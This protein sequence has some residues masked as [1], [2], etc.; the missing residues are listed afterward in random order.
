MIERINRARQKLMESVEPA[1]A[2]LESVR[3][4][5]R[6][7]QYRQ[8][9]QEGVGIS[10]D[11]LDANQLRELTDSMWMARAGIGDNS[12]EECPF[13]DVIVEAGDRLAR[14]GVDEYAF[15]SEWP[16]RCSAK[17]SGLAG[18]RKPS[19]STT[20]LWSVLAQQMNRHY[21]SKQPVRIALDTTG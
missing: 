16:K 14:L 15:K 12:P 6:R 3:N 5:L 4:A 1:E 18:M 7:S 17:V 13:Y 19:T 2:R 21:G 8:A 9:V 10:Q 11:D 20:P